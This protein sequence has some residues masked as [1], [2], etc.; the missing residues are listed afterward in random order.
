MT[1]RRRSSRK[2]RKTVKYWYIALFAVIIFM[3]YWFYADISGFFSPGKQR[4]DDYSNFKKSLSDYSVFGIDIS[5]YQA[6]IDWDKLKKEESPS[7]VIIRATA[8]KDKKDNKFDFNWKSAKQKGILRGAYHYYRPDENSTE[9]ALFFIKT[10]KIEEGDLPPVLDIEKYSRVQ[11]LPSLKSGLL[12]WLTIVEEHYSVTPILYTFNKFYIS[13]IVHDQR[14]EQYPLWI[15]WY[16]IK[17]DPNAIAPNWIFWQFSDKG[18]IK[19]IE[20]DVDVN[21]FNGKIKDLEGLKVRK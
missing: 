17:G 21:V 9:Q 10:V 18:R 11:S 2:S 1:K 7:F 20:G 16:N 14:F 12:N 13:T 19:G 6:V 8:G 15:A 4:R 3:L 5:Q